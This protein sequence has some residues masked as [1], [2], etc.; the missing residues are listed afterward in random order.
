GS[1]VLGTISVC[2]RRRKVLGMAGITMTLVAAL[3][4]GSRV[5]VEG[6]VGRGPFLGLDWFVLN[7]IVYSAV[8]IPLERLF[9]RLPEQPIF[10]R[11]WRTDLAYF[12]FSALFLQVTT[13]LTMKP[14]MVFF[15]WASNAGA[16]RWIAAQSYALQ[17]A[18]IL[19]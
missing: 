17:F 12:F 19:L 5:P 2:L 16:Q 1:F 11:G 3:L 6:Q 9:A 10:R 8:F 4:G 18:G 15:S 13:I 7:L 14:A